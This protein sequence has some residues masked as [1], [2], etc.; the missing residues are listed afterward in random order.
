M[1]LTNGFTRQQ[2]GSCISPRKLDLTLLSTEKCNFRCVYCYEE[3]ELG[4]MP[5]HVVEGVCNLITRR[6]EAGLEDL[7]LSWFGGE[8]LIALKVVRAICQHSFRESERFGFKLRGGFTTNAYTLTPDLLAELVALKQSF[9][10]ITLDGW[11]DAHDA[12]RLRADGKGTFD[13]IWRNLL[14]ARD[15]ILNFRI[16]LRV[17]IT[18]TNHTSLVTLCSAIGQEFGEDSRFH[19]DFQDVRDMGGENGT[20]VNAVSASDFKGIKWH[21]RGLVKGGADSCGRRSENSPGHGY[22][23]GKPECL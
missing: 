6:A 5:P 3:F 12:T 11:R 2:I 8:P 17:H 21:L 14:A 23:A 15:T 13:V 22:R 10:Q 19:V 18:N 9:F 4:A 16:V 20:H 7:S 1:E